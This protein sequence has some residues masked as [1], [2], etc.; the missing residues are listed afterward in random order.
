M[1][2]LGKLLLLAGLFFLAYA[3]FSKF[4]GAPC[5]A[6]NG[7]VQ[8]RSLLIVGN[9]CLLLSLIATVRDLCKK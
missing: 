1:K 2:I 9:A 8:S 3:V 6:F 4:Y 7:L 5:V